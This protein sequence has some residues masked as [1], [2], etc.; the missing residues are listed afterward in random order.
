MLSVIQML[1]Q[2]WNHLDDPWE[3]LPE[4]QCGRCG[5][6]TDRDQNWLN[7]CFGLCLLSCRW[8]RTIAGHFGQQA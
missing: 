2:F 4:E 5:Y 1:I 8:L 6:K 3:H 7:M